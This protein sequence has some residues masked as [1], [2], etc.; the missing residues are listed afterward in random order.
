MDKKVTT[1]ALG[2]VSGFRVRSL[3]NIALN[4][5]IVLKT[6]AQIYSFHTNLSQLWHLYANLNQIFPGE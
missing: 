5:T 4:K 3:K 6:L 1:L 2:F